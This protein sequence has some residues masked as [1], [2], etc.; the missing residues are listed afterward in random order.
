MVIHTIHVNVCFGKRACSCVCV[1]TTAPQ[2]V[3]R[4]VIFYFYFSTDRPRS[5]PQP[6]RAT[7]YFKLACVRRQMDHVQNI[8]VLMGFES[9]SNFP[10]LTCA[11][12]HAKSRATGL[13]DVILSTC[14]FSRG[15]SHGIS[16]KAD[17]LTRE[18]TSFPLVQVETF[19][20]HR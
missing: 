11:H 13:S 6:A 7:Q 5:G 19:L 10:Y 9:V 15:R 8:L 2:S 17:V 14:I 1:Y 12:K 18:S 4:R 3:Q 16:T 20:C